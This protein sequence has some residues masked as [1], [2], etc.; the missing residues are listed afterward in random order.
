V[1]QGERPQQGVQRQP[2]VTPALDEQ[3]AR[4]Q[5]GDRRRRVR[6]ADRLAQRRGEPPEAR[7]GPDELRDGFALPAEELLRQVREERA[8]RPPH[9]V[10]RRNAR[11]RRQRRQRVD[12][13]TEGRRPTPGE[14]VQRGRQLRRESGHRCAEE[15]LDLRSRERKELGTDPH[16]LALAVEPGD[17]EREP[18]TG[19]QDQVQAGGR[20]AAQSSHELGALALRADHMQVVHDQHGV[21]PELLSQQLRHVA[22][23][24]DGVAFRI[25]GGRAARQLRDRIRRNPRHRRAERTGDP[26][27]DRGEIG[28]ARVQAVP[29]R[30][31]RCR[32]RPQDGR[33]AEARPSQDH[34]EAAVE[35]LTQSIGDSGAGQEPRRLRGRSRLRGLRH[36]EIPPPSIPPPPTLRG[37]SHRRQVPCLPN[38]G[39]A[40]LSSALGRAVLRSSR[41][42]GRC[43]DCVAPRAYV[44]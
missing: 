43:E 41:V 4:G 29:R 27:D 18:R 16:H 11:L 12:G 44:F 6:D 34:G 25:R 30:A 14:L 24:R 19:R 15:L 1:L 13:E 37:Q 32:P 8:A 17:R 9:G 33:L 35:R 20:L 22:R 38:A 31:D 2:A 39:S 23:H 42:S 40:A 28:V 36:D 3:P 5:L 26:A 7:R 21:A 10:E